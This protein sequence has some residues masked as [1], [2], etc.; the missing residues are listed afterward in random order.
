MLLAV[1]DFQA[2]YCMSLYRDTFFK[3]VKAYHLSLPRTLLEFANGKRS[4][5]RPVT[6]IPL[7]FPS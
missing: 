3:P 7:S 5:V 4:F 1:D 2:L 6:R